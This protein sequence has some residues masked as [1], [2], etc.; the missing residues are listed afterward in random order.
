MA[1][2]RKRFKYYLRNVRSV[3]HLNE[4]NEANNIVGRSDYSIEEIPGRGLIKLDEPTLFQTAL[5]NDGTNAIEIIQN[6]QD[7]ASKMSEFWKGEIPEN[8]PMVPEELH[9][10][11]FISKKKTKNMLKEKA[12]LPI[13]LEFE[14][15]SPVGVSLSQHN[16]TVV[17]PS[18][19]ML[20]Q[21]ITNAGQLLVEKEIKELVVIDTPAMDLIKLKELP[22]T[23]I[24]NSE[25]IEDK[26]ALVYDIFKTMEK[27]YLEELNDDN[28][29]TKEVYFEKITPQVIIINSIVQIYN[30]LSMDTQ[31]QLLELL[32]TD[33]KMGIQFITG[34]DL[35]SIAKEY[36]PIGDYIRAAKQVL[37]GVRFADQAAY[38][39]TIRITQEKPLA[40]QEIYLLLEGKAERLK[41]PKG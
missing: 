12:L 39:S 16:L 6:N 15:A 29:L 4:K 14:Y 22:L 5:P 26:I 40:P 41:I 8:I 31:K 3:A 7:E 23:Y 25:R 17:M 13:G 27:A 18:I 1:K 34:N 19:E 35:G 20:N 30:Q 36:S 11:N 28:T 21:V 38:S 9:F 37:L 10:A 24:S 2:R 32:K 33:G